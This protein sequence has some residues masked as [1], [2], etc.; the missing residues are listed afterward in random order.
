M[1]IAHVQAHTGG[2]DKNALVSTCTCTLSAAVALGNTLFVATAVDNFAGTLNS[3]PVTGISKPS[4]ETATW[5]KIGPSI[6]STGAGAGGG[7][8]VVG[9][10]WG[11]TTAMIWPSTFTPVVTFSITRTAKAVAIEEFSGASTTERGTTVTGPSTIGTPTAT[12]T[13]PLTGDLVIGASGWES[14]TNPTGA[15]DTT[16]G[17]WSALTIA[18][19]TG[20]VDNANML[21]AIQWKI[22]TADGSQTYSPTGISTDATVIVAALEPGGGGGGGGGGGHYGSTI[23]SGTKVALTADSVIRSGTKTAGTFSVIRSGTKLP[24]VV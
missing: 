13:A 11:I 18:K 2:V 6:E 19:T 5:T 22:V 4:G 16:N 8:A 15:S 20:G 21:A 12:N 7:T 10:L 23:R 9:E 1:A 14:T 24:L 3:P 17:S